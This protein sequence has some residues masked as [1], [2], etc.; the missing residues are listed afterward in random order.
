MK[1]TLMY[2]TM[3]TWIL[4]QKWKFKNY[5]A[6]NDVAPP[7]ECM[8]FLLNM[9][10]TKQVKCMGIE[11][12]LPCTENALINAVKA[13]SVDCVK[14]LINNNAPKSTTLLNIAYENKNNAIID[15]LKLAGIK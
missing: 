4:L 7:C 14:W 12:R 8:G 5:Y 2:C 10:L 1:D 11:Y 6:D 15:I 3:I 9:A 13:D